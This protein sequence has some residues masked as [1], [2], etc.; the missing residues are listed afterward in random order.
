MAT[1]QAADPDNRINQAARRIQR[2]NFNWR[3]T[4]L[5]TAASWHPSAPSGRAVFGADPQASAGR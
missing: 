5:Q 2:L 3:T 1:D 4:V